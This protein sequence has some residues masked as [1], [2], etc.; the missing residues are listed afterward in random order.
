MRTT[1]GFAFRTHSGT[2]SPEERNSALS[3]SQQM[4]TD[5]TSVP[6]AED[7]WA[8]RTHFRSFQVTTL[9]DAPLR[10]FQVR[11]QDGPHMC[12]FETNEISWKQVCCD[13]LTCESPN[14]CSNCNCALL[15]PMDD[16]GQQLQLCPGWSTFRR[17]SRQM[18]TLS[19]SCDPAV[20]TTS[21]QLWDFTTALVAFFPAF[22]NQDVNKIQPEMCES[23]LGP[24][25]N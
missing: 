12:E 20:T 17:Q 6:S 8:F 10:Y 18:Q 13:L 11:T 5:I 24:A 25:L 1:R 9:R 16:S 19:S 21:G 15:M 7:K 3:G 4:I 2:I 22:N 14:G 23:S